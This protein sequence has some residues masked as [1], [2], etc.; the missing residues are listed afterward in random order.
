MAAQSI[1]FF[2][3]SYL[4]ISTSSRYEKQVGT[5]SGEKASRLYNENSFLLNLQ[6]MIAL[7][8]HP[9]PP[10]EALIRTHF[11][12]SRDA[13]LSRAQRY[14]DLARDGVAVS[15]TEDPSGIACPPSRGFCK[16]LEQ[17]L[18]KLRDVFNTLNV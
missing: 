12:L 5:A 10:F 14:L 4:L 8:R 1:Q 17:V 7:A 2:I 15:E 13:I 3:R 9:L 16:M 11:A 18:P 6:S